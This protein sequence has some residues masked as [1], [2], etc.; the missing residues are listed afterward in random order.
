MARIGA[1]IEAETLLTETGIA[2]ETETE[3]FEG[4]APKNATRIAIATE[5]IG[6]E[7]WRTSQ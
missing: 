1:G 7:K 3:M 5:E 2:I 6:M 4:L